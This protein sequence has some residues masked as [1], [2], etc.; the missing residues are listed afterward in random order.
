[1][2]VEVT[3]LVHERGEVRG[4]EARDVET[5]T[6]HVVRARAVINATGIFTDRLRR[7]DDEEAKPIITTSQGIHLV[8]D[9]AFLPGETAIMVPKTDD[10]RV[11]FAIP[12]HDR[13]VVGT[14][15]TEVPEPELEPRP[16]QE[17]LEYLFEHTARYLTHDPTPADVKSVFAGLRPLVGDPDG[18]GTAALSR[19][20]TLL[21]SASGLVTITG[22]KWTTYRKMAE[23]TIDQAALLADLPERES[24]TRDLPIHGYDERAERHGDLAEYG[25]DAPAV[26]AVIAERAAWGERLHPDQP[27]R[28]GEVVWAVRREMARTAEDVLSRRRRMLILDA[29]ASIE[30]APAVAALMAEAMGRDEAWQ[31]AQVEAYRALAAGYLVDGA[32]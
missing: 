10:G 7:M 2:S 12:W 6:E 32:A 5:G 23:D 8:L 19:D 25:S 14:T 27:M 29:R 22:G 30:A 13:L 11:L 17:E 15:D 18:E 9:R 3:G 26:E 1:M 24:V 21:I 20:H 4:V 16:L 31:R 28:A